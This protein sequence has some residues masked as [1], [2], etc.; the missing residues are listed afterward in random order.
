[1]PNLSFA[2]KEEVSLEKKVEL[3][4]N[5]VETN[6]EDFDDVYEITKCA[7]W[8]ESNSFQRV[9]NIYF[10]SISNTISIN[11]RYVFNFLIIYCLI[12]HKLVKDYKS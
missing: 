5:I 12:Q 10:I 11:Y 8:I 6:L 7:K 4:E 1:M 2:T 3:L 9:N